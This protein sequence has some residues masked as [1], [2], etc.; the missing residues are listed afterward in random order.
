MNNATS[1]TKRSEPNPI[2][3]ARTRLAVTQLGLAVLLGVSPSWIG[4]IE[5]APVY[6]SDRIRRKLAVV[7]AKAGK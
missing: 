7:L 1:I 6:L 2:L 4:V 3:D 5:R